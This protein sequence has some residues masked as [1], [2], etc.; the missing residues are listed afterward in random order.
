MLTLSPTSLALYKECKRCFWLQ[1]NQRIYRPKSI[2]P[3]LPNGIDFVLKQYFDHYRLRG[4]LPPE[5]KGVVEGKLFPD[6]TV[7]AKW[8]NYRQ[9]LSHL[10]ESAN[11]ML[12]GVLDDC[13]VEKNGL[14]PL[15]YKTRGY[16]VKENSHS[17]YQNQL[18]SYCFLLQSYGY[19]VPQYAYLVYYYPQ[20]VSEHGLFQFV[21]EPYKIATDA[22]SAHTLFREAV[23]LL[24]E[25]M[26]QNGTVCEYCKWAQQVVNGFAV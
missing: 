14:V 16:A 3:S 15:D 23:Q 17:Y 8:R 21:V 13:V 11:A 22:K 20:R 26:P 5:I 7:L 24:R 19:T 2:F 18:D 1:M 10:D 6:Q 25:P 12:L 9:G 4:I